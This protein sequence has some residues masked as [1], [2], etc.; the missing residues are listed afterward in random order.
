MQKHMRE[1]IS[2]Q[3]IKYNIMCTLTRTD[4]EKLGNVVVYIANHTINLSKTKLLKLLYFMEEYSVRRFQT[5]F[6]G[7][8]YEVWQAGPV[9]KD[10]FIDLSETPVILDGYIKK[11]VVRNAT[12]IIATSDFCDD[13]FSDNDIL[14]MDEVIKKYGSKTASEL[15]G[16]THGQGT[17]WYRTAKENGLLSKFEQKLMNN[18]DVVIDFGEEL[19]PCGRDFYIEQMDSLKASRFYEK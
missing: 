4:R 1:V 6:L 7:L 18:S 9:V 12:Y 5:P 11:K 19:T 14:V 13:E 3:E 17:L 15:V 10:V 2:L 8:S 16:I